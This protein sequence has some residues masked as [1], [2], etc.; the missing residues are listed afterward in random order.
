MSLGGKFIEQLREAHVIWQEFEESKNWPARIVTIVIGSPTPTD[1]S[2]GE[3]VTDSRAE[4]AMVITTHTSMTAFAPMSIPNMS[5][6][7]PVLISLSVTQPRPR[8]TII[9]CRQPG[10]VPET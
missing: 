7:V 5:V 9:R 4:V 3:A 1:S 2:E 10:S 8:T 6:P